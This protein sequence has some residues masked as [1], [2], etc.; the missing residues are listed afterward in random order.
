M[1]GLLCHLQVIVER[2][3]AG[4]KDPLKDAFNLFLDFAA[5]FVRLLIILLNNAE[6]KERRERRERQRE[7]RSKNARTSRL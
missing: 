3:E 1:D 6:K 7:G 4:M 5:I 2:C